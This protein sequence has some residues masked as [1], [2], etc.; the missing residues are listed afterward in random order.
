MALLHKLSGLNLCRIK[1]LNLS[2]VMIHKI[3]LILC[4]WK[5]KIRKE[6]NRIKG[7]K[8]LPLNRSRSV[9]KVK[10]IDLALNPVAI[11][12][13]RNVILR[14]DAYKKMQSKINHK[15]K[16]INQINHRMI[17]NRRRRNRNLKRKYRNKTK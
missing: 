8:D 6:A 14:Y 10:K 11:M 16:E 9:E 4:K 3:N 7:L 12:N 15:I 13:H 5:R 1:K 2:S 17:S